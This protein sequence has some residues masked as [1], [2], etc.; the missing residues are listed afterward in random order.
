MVTDIQ[1]VTNLIKKGHKGL[2]LVVFDVIWTAIL[3]RCGNV[4]IPAI[5]LYIYIENGAICDKPQSLLDVLL[6]AHSRYI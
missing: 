6:Q 1:Q 2:F 5:F 4:P 3:K